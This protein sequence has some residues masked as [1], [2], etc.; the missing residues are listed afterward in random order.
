MS[1]YRVVNGD[2]FARLIEHMRISVP[3]SIR[4][5]ERTLA[6]R[7]EIL[8]EAE[9]EA[10]RIIQEANTRARSMLSDN[11]LVQA[12]QREAER[13]VMS[14][15]EQA[16]EHSRSADAYATEVLEE[17]AEKLRIISQQVD[18]GIRILQEKS[19]VARE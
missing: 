11:A 5:S 18:N 14:S 6:E 9:E 10:R 13:I 7:D 16:D 12:A 3:S 2:E 17:L 15:K 4:E 19:P 8:A 1:P